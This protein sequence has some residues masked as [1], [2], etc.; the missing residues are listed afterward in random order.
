MSV[1]VKICGNTNLA[2]ADCAVRAGADALGFIF[3]AKSP[4]FMQADTVRAI[5]DALPQ[6]IRKV[7]IFV[8]EPAALVR[9][10][11]A[12]AALTSVQLAGSES[13]EQCAELARDFEV[14]KVFHVGP[15]FDSE[16]LRAYEVAAFLFD[17]P[18]PIH[19]G[20]GKTFDWSLLRGVREQLQGRTPFY[21]AG[22][23]SPENVAD[24]I[25]QVEPD[26]V[27]VC[28][29]VERA[30]GCKDHEKIRAFISAAQAVALGR[31]PQ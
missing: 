12:A 20:S 15:G 6:G 10:I 26:G 4:R 3:Y 19:G 2:D 30:P 14:L 22:G 11:A 28:S 25:A 24:A 18:S 1:R 23:L 5:V 7:G 13:P 27:D 29:G 17:T 31:S 16:L 21:L 9:D 8:N